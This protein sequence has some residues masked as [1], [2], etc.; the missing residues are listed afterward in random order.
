MLGDAIL[1]VEEPPSVLRT[2]LVIAVKLLWGTSPLIP[3][4]LTWT[5]L[6]LTQQCW[7]LLRLLCRTT[8]TGWHPLLLPPV[9][10]ALSDIPLLVS[11][12]KK[13]HNLSYLSP[14]VL[15]VTSLTPPPPPWRGALLPTIEP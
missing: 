8:V 7:A 4:F 3:L 13:M 5:I 10:G 6:L 1:L 9:R 15:N 12:W 11:R 14:A 2:R